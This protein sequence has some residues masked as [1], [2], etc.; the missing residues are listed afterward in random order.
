MAKVPSKGVAENLRKF[1]P[2]NTL[3]PGALQR[4][5][6]D[7]RFESIGMGEFLFRKGDTDQQHIYLL[8]G[9]VSLMSERVELDV[10]VGGSNLAKFPL[11]HRIPRE[12][13]AI[14]KSQCEI[15]R[16]EGTRLMP[17]LKEAERVSSQ[18]DHSQDTGGDWMTQLLRSRVF[19]QIPPA[20]IQAVMRRMTPVEV[21]AGQEITRQGE[22]GD[23]FYLINRGSCQ[24][25]RTTNDDDTELL[26]ELGPGE[27]FGEEALLS[28]RPRG[29]T[30]TMIE[31]GILLQL[32]AEDFSNYVKNSLFRSVAFQEAQELATAGAVW[33]DVRRTSEFRTIHIPGSVNIPLSQLRER[34]AELSQ[35]SCHIVCCKDEQSSTTAAFLLIEAGIE[36]VLLKGGISGLSQEMLDTYLADTDSSHSGDQDGMSKADAESDG[37]L[38]QGQ[39]EHALIQ[40]LEQV[41]GER[42]DAKEQLEMALGK[43]AMLEK[44]LVEQQCEAAEGG[45][46]TPP[47]VV[48]LRAE[49]ATLS[50]A[51][52]E[53][54]EDYEK[55][56]AR[57]EAAEAECDRL[58]RAQPAGAGGQD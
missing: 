41:R 50:V 10:V 28:N 35:E 1:I 55:T 36:V 46:N 14:A 48:A 4:L 43:I 7:I 21:E 20:N 33:L 51:L 53:S 32:S 26:A 17:L 3:S 2:L 49:L 30:V 37:A 47:D 25:S 39:G 12:C 11:A 18:K 56:L 42:D 45:A 27:C 58:K 16:V 9:R 24:V 23:C 54:Y 34:L 22:S 29:C 31:S 19:Q 38:P 15:A 40:A 5:S 57:A 6:A 52:D 13:S 8:S 44:L